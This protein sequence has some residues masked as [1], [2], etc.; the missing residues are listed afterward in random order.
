MPADLGHIVAEVSG[1]QRADVDKL[2]Q[3]AGDNLKKLGMQFA[4]PDPEAFRAVLRN[5]GWYKEWKEKMGAQ[6]W[7]TLEK[8]AGQLG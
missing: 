1:E 4:S 3:T 7:A 8:Y 5:V 6:A 2:N